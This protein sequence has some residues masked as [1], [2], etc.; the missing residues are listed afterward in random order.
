MASYRKTVS[1]HTIERWN[2]VPLEN[3]G[4]DTPGP[5]GAP[6]IYGRMGRTA[7]LSASPGGIADTLLL[8]NSNDFI[9]FTRKAVLAEAGTEIHQG[10]EDG[11]RLL[12][13]RKSALTGANPSSAWITESLTMAKEKARGALTMKTSMAQSAMVDHVFDK[14]GSDF[15]SNAN[16]DILIE[17]P[18]QSAVERAGAPILAGIPDLVYFSKQDGKVS[19]H[20]HD[21]KTGFEAL[22]TGHHIKGTALNKFQNS[23]QTQIYPILAADYL[24]KGDINNISSFNMSYHSIDESM[25]GLKTF[26]VIN[27]FDGSKLAEMKSRMVTETAKFQTVRSIA[28]NA[29]KEDGQRGLNS[30]LKEFM[31]NSGCNTPNM[32]QHCPLK[33]NC[34]YRTLTYEIQSNLSGRAQNPLDGNV[35]LKDEES[36]FLRLSNAVDEDLEHRI[37]RVR[38]KTKKENARLVEDFKDSYRK[39]Y[40]QSV[41]SDVLDTRVSSMADEYSKSLANLNRNVVGLRKDITVETSK[42]IIDSITANAKL[43]FSILDPEMRPPWMTGKFRTEMTNIANQ[44]ITEVANALGSNGNTINKEVLDYVFSNKRIASMIESNII[45]NTSNHFMNRGIHDPSDNEIRGAMKDYRYSMNQGLTNSLMGEIDKATI[46]RVMATE[47]SKI[48]R[49]L[50]SG[51]NT[52]RNEGAETIA[53]VLYNSHAVKSDFRDIRKQLIK[54]GSFAGTLA[55]NGTVPKFPL[56]AGAAVMMLSY[57]A[58]V[59]SIRRIIARKVE[60]STDA[61]IENARGDNREVDDGTHASA[62]TTSRRLMSSDF[63]SK[64]K[65]WQ[66]IG[67]LRNWLGL[68]HHDT[69]DLKDALTMGYAERE[70]TQGAGK[71]EGLTIG[72]LI[73]SRPGTAFTA[74]AVLGFVTYGILTHI[75]TDR[76]IGKSTDERKERAQSLKDLNWN[77]RDSRMVSP[78]STLRHGYRLHTEFG[79]ALQFG[80][81]A[82]A[83]MSYDYKEVFSKLIKDWDLGKE[84]LTTSLKKP[85][86]NSSTYIRR[87]S[88][89]KPLEVAS[90]KLH[91]IMNDPKTVIKSATTRAKFLVETSSNEVRQKAMRTGR[92]VPEALDRW[93]EAAYTTLFEKGYARKAQFLVRQN[94]H[95]AVDAATAVMPMPTTKG[96][97]NTTGTYESRSGLR[98]Q[99]K[100]TNNAVFTDIDGVPSHTPTISPESMVNRSTT[101]KPA[102]VKIGRKNNKSYIREHIQGKVSATSSVATASETVIHT[103]NTDIEEHSTRKGRKRR[104]KSEEIGYT[105]G[106]VKQSEGVEYD[107]P[108]LERR[109]AVQ[110]ATVPATMKGYMPGYPV[111]S[112]ARSLDINYS[113]RVSMSTVHSLHHRNLSRYNK[114]M[115]MG[116]GVTI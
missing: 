41:P 50:G 28:Y 19:F 57:I 34:P 79:S 14:I 82:K 96:I 26:N 112:S 99:A 107:I 97:V 60:K 104:V 95:M 15:L 27:N 45:D 16:A 32:C 64:T 20:V 73:K 31:A 88:E 10:F 30:V 5:R 80:R 36:K 4:G 55:R 89:K 83:I 68:G 113:R 94:S 100:M 106:N 51:I 84:R 72:S 35:P 87:I 105:G 90:R 38:A 77:I 70:L 53:K 37:H 62:Y 91:V 65:K 21:W 49:L 74:A 115:T 110:K 23:Y 33:F 78:E 48:E 42:N 114:N 69:M 58:G 101:I 93:R 61:M 103:K 3:Q 52:L 17:K 8:K 24:A 86:E 9:S 47:G 46:D 54:T 1:P 67:T 22:H 76:E 39:R 92:K 18:M 11:F 12:K 40:A 63:G 6:S 2:G 98:S 66:P 59:D 29:L 71:I 44:R 116:P 102:T 13:D 56:A 108:T 25:R 111:V 75:G 81:M 85:A 43:P 109:M 7:G